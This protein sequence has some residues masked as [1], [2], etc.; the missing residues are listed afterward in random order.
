[1]NYTRQEIIDYIKSNITKSA[2]NDLKNEFGYPKTIETLNKIFEQENYTFDKEIAYTYYL[3]EGF[4][5]LIIVDILKT[6]FDPV[7]VLEDKYNTDNL[8]TKKHPNPYDYASQD[9]YEK[10]VEE[11]N[12]HNLDV[13]KRK[14]SANN[15]LNKLITKRQEQLAL[16]E[17]E[18]QEIINLYTTKDWRQEGFKKHTKDHPLKTQVV[19]IKDKHESNYG[20]GYYVRSVPIVREDKINIK[21]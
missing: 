10:A 12:N 14:Q 9:K 3:D 20:N 13:A 15:T 8:L 17:Q 11:V 2:W 4:I 5:D 6:N 19:E 18:K 1:M 21:G 7:K 16:D